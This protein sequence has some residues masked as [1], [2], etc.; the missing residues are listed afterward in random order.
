MKDKKII[1]REEYYSHHVV[2]PNCKSDEDL[3][4]SNIL[5]IT[6]VAKD[7]VDKLNTARC[8]KCGWKGM[9]NQLLPNGKE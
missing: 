2:C 9:R 3:F 7:Y 4:A 8:G 5:L 6:S 1:T